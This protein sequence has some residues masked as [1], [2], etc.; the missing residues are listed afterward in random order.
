MDRLQETGGRWGYGS[1]T[2]L[3][4]DGSKGG[5]PRTID[6]VTP[7]AREAIK[8]LIKDLQPGQLILQKRDGSKYQSSSITR[9]ISRIA[10]KLDLSQDY[11]QNRNHALRKAFAQASYD[12]LRR[13]GVSKREALDYASKQLGHGAN[14]TDLANAYISDQW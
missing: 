6:L 2:I 9:Q 1:F 11:K 4:G 8:E 7:Q 13:T 12:H 10:G 3:K 14:R 5:R